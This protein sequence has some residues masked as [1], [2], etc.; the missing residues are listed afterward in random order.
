MKL[1][2]I[3]VFLLFYNFYNVNSSALNVGDVLMVN[4]TS[5][6]GGGTLTSMVRGIFSG[7]LGYGENIDYF[8]FNDASGNIYT[9]NVAAWPA[10]VTLAT[11]VAT[12]AVNSAT[13]P[14]IISNNITAISNQGSLAIVMTNTQIMTF[15]SGS[16]FDNAP[17]TITNNPQTNMYM[18]C[19][20]KN[21]GN[22]DLFVTLFSNSNVLSIFQYGMVSNVIQNPTYFGPNV[23]LST[24]IKF[25]LNDGMGYNIYGGGSVIYVQSETSSIPITAT[26]ANYSF[27]TAVLGV[28]QGVRYIYLCTLNASGQ[29]FLMVYS[30]NNET[31][32]P[33]FSNAAFMGYG[34]ECLS[35]T[36]DSAAGQVF[37][38]W[39]GYANTLTVSTIGVDC[40]GYDQRYV[41]P[42]NV[43]SN[44][45][46]QSTF[47]Y[48]IGTRNSTLYI[49]TPDAKVHMIKYTN[50]CPNLC[51][52]HGTCYGGTCTCSPEY[53]GKNCAYPPPVFTSLDPIPYTSPN[54]T[55]S[56]IGQQFINDTLVI[57]IGSLTCENST[58]VSETLLTCALPLDSTISWVPTQ[59]Q[60]V[61]IKF[62]TVEYNMPILKL[63]IFILPHIIA[64]SQLNSKII[65]E[66]N[67][68][69]PLQYMQVEL[70]GVNLTCAFEVGQDILSCDIPDI[71]PN[72]TNTISIPSVNYENR[73][74][75]IPYIYDIS[76][77]VFKAD[78][79][80]EVTISGIAFATSEGTE[81]FKVLQGT[82]SITVNSSSVS[83]RSIIFTPNNGIVTTKTISVQ[84]GDIQSNSVTY[85]YIAPTITQVTQKDSPNNEF[86]ISGDNFGT[87][88]VLVQVHV[89]T[90]SNTL[91]MTVLNVTQN[92]IVFRGIEN[93]RKG[94][95]TVDVDGQSNNL[96]IDL[97]LIPRVTSISPLPPTS[98]GLVTI[99]GQYLYDTLITLN[100]DVNDNVSLSCSFKT[101][102]NY[103][104]EAYCTLLP[105]CGFFTIKVKSVYPG[106]Q[107]TI[108]F[109]SNYHEPVISSISPKS[110]KRSANQTFT[111]S[112]QNIEERNLEVTIYDQPC[113]VT[114][115]LPPT[116]VIC[117]YISD[118]DPE[119]VENPVNITIS[120]NHIVGSNK[121]LL[122]FEKSCPNNCS[123]NGQCNIADGKCKCNESYNGAD[124]STF[125]P[126]ASSEPDN[127]SPST[128]LVTNIF[129]ITTIL[130]LITTIFI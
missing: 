126:P 108:D 7:T 116:Q 129:T 109:E 67:D 34:Y 63:N 4:L 95:V 58:W 106:G 112:G 56:I 77:S 3:F 88:V 20:S 113:N 28:S 85:T 39:F 121:Q 100:S 117:E 94:K 41:L 53:V 51:S 10:G 107:D 73:L 87:S 111:I 22:T 110:Y 43:V 13:S 102:S 14:L 52:G 33:E 42:Y 115:V 9:F 92:S 45:P 29:V 89:T 81:T 46:G 12:T 90:Q 69:L 57:T 18:R 118:V 123:S 93:M 79:S 26:L 68:F 75:L 62:T 5:I 8:L 96:G 122:S 76:P 25:F 125:V 37:F 105:D 127:I 2:L 104:S 86:S 60:Y 98:G 17:K 70:S 50:L 74:L 101:I 35:A 65:V 38:S 48:P 47:S 66:G 19:N 103:P 31:G 120:V 23:Q 80:Q 11:S 99:N 91:D 44:Q 130:S 6:G 124:C 32:A 30:Y 83:G 27:Y 64:V 82:L 36:I 72:R 15:A 55:I 21:Q 84:V 59:S 114:E 16:V 78:N 71:I 119:T 61:S 24:S 1:N 40:K 97:N 54:S 49:A 128:K